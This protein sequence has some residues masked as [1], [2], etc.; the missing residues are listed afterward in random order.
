MSRLK[1]GLSCLI[2]YLNYVKD[3]LLRVVFS[4]LFSVFR[5]VV[6]FFFKRSLVSNILRFAEIYLDFLSERSIFDVTALLALMYFAPR[7]LAFS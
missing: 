3:T 2:H 5:N 1:Q 7:A 6:V 4:T